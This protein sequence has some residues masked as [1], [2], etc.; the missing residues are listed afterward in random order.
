VTA[1]D[2]N[3][4]VYAHRVE[5]SR[6]DRARQALVALAESPR[7]WA[8]P[9][10]CIGEFLRVI[11]HRRLFDPPFTPA[12]AV[13]AL[14]RVLASPSL[15]VLMPGDYFVPLLA[16][17]MREA[18]VSGNLVFDAQIV[19]LCREAGVSELLTEDRD[20]ARFAAFRTRRLDPS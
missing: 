8:I 2:T 4:L 14:Q 9:I 6:H 10:F 5:Q 3:I 15:R 7:P 13:E 20:F 16:E 19:A 12:E 18:E 1:V 17:A 11:T